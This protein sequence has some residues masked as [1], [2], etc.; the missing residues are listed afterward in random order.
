MASTSCVSATFGLTAGRED[1]DA[2]RREFGIVCKPSQRIEG[3]TVGIGYRPVL[4][5]HVVVTDADA[6][7]QTPH[8]VVDVLRRTDRCDA[9]SDP[10]SYTVFCQTCV[11]IVHTH[12][13]NAGRKDGVEFF[14]HFTEEAELAGLVGSDVENLRDAI[15]GEAYEVKR[16]YKDFA[17]AAAKDGDAD[18][19][20]R[21]DEVRNDE[22]KH[23]EAFKAMLEK[24][25]AS[26]S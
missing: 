18:A 10:L 16:M 21:F 14:E 7:H 6:E 25:E 22:K 1:L 24:V 17:K 4:Q 13:G 2:S 11:A 19:A 12:P 5:M 23:R 3:V 20:A 26:E 15:S 8:E 9:V